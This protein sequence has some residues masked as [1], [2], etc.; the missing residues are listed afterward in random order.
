MNGPFDV[1]SDDI[2]ISDGISDNTQPDRQVI[3]NRS[4][5]VTHCWMD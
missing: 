3:D 4:T 5:H 2:C 1:A